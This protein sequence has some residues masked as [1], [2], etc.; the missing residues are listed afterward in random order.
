MTE[1]INFKTGSALTALVKEESEKLR[2][3]GA[4]VI[5]YV[6]HDGTTYSSLTVSEYY[7]I[8]LSSG[9]YVDVVFGGHTHS[10]Y[11]IKNDG[12]STIEPIAVIS[13]SFNNISSIMP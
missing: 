6:I 11:I 13:Y 1:G 5:I 3:Q 8:S 9:G 7:D 2:E 10:Y 4:D 12:C